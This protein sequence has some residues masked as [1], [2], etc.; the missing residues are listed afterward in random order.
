[1]RLYRERYTGFN[2]RHF[3]EIVGRDHGIT[4]PYSYVT[5]A[6]QQAGLLR[7][8]GVRGRHRRPRE[9]RPCF[10]ELLHLG[11]RPHRWLALAP[12]A[13]DVHHGGG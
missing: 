8:R 11:G 13:G 6:L 2:R 10:G 4:L 3:H 9:P 5:R 1:M 7:K 12:H